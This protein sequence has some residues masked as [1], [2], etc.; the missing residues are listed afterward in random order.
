MTEP[1]RYLVTYR[2]MG[3]YMPGPM[4]LEQRQVSVVAYSARDAAEQVELVLSE[5][6]AMGI[7]SGD[8][9]WKVRALSVEPCP[10]DFA[11]PDVKSEKGPKE[12]GNEHYANYKNWPAELKNIEDLTPDERERLYGK[13]KSA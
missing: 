1:N 10:V 12:V 5:P 3:A 11:G 2:F 9:A 8:C 7:G 6:G 4:N 13:A